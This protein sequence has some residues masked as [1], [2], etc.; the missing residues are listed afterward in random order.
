[1]SW[2]SRV[3]WCEGLMLRVEQRWSWDRKRDER[4]WGKFET[5]LRDGYVVM[6]R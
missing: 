3:R 1:M 6:K 4:T 2:G 5:G